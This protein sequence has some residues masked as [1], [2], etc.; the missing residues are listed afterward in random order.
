MGVAAAN[1]TNDVARP[2]GAPLS[3]LCK[4][5]YECSENKKDKWELQIKQWYPGITE[6][7]LH[8]L[9]MLNQESALHISENENTNCKCY[10]ESDYYNKDICLVKIP[11]KD[12]NCDYGY[13]DYS[14]P[15]IIEDDFSIFGIDK[16]MLRSGITFSIKHE[17]YSSPQIEFEFDDYANF[18]ITNVLGCHGISIHDKDCN[19]FY[20]EI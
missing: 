4:L 1:A 17:K 3:E 10:F 12:R 6:E 20:Y 9:F 8:E 11:P 7:H 16:K 5:R 14:D 13:S 15:K 19:F 18:V 2:G